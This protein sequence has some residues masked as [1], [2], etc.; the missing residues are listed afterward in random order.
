LATAFFAL[1]L[2]ALN[3]ATIGL[4]FFAI[5]KKFFS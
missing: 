3:T 5:S 1:F 4:W 2:S